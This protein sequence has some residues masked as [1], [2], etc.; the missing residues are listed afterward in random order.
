MAGYIT[1]TV[2][3]AVLEVRGDDFVRTA[4][5]KGL[6]EREI[7]VRHVLRNASLPIVT[8]LGLQFGSLLGG[9]LITEVAVS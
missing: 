9:A 8:V 7:V 6:T 2:R 4:R 3:A 1:R 5:M